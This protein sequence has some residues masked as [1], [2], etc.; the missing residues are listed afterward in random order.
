MGATVSEPFLG[1]V[2]YTVPLTRNLSS[3][4]LSLVPIISQDL[5]HSRLS[6]YLLERLGNHWV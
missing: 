5:L 1:Q 3:D 4:L 2:L 6:K